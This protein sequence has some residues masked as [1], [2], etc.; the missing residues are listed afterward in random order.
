[1]SQPISSNIKILSVIT[2]AGLLLYLM[3]DDKKVSE[4]I[5][6]KK[7]TSAQG[8][9]LINC[10]KFRIVNLPTMVENF[11]TKLNQLVLKPQFVV[12]SKIEVGLFIEDFLWLVSPKCYNALLGGSTD[13]GEYFNSKVNKVQFIISYF[14]MFGA[15]SNYFNNILH[16]ENPYGEWT[17]FFANQDE[18]LAFKNKKF[19]DFDQYFSP[20]FIKFKI[21]PNQ[22]LN[23]FQ[24]INSGD[25]KEIS[26]TTIDYITNPYK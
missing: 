14:L 3:S 9:L 4:G 21:I 11:A 8:Y 18:V 10:E 12:P 13:K 7:L 23:Y 19:T 25:I 16:I 2:G 24:R 5:D 1:M 15:L 6:F 17:K 26:A 22:V 20:L